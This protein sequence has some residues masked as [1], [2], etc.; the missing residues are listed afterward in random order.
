[1]DDISLARVQI[2]FWTLLNLGLFVIKSILDG[3]IWEVGNGRPDGYVLGCYLSPK[4]LKGGE[5][6]EEVY[7]LIIL[8]ATNPR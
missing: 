6:P 2:L 7:P 4:I 5:T 8:H 3:E 1:M